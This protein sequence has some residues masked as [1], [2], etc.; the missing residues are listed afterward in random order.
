MFPLLTSRRSTPSLQI[1]GMWSCKRVSRCFWKALHKRFTLSGQSSSDGVPK[2][3]LMKQMPTLIFLRCLTR[4][5]KVQWN[6]L[7]ENFIKLVSFTL[8]TEKGRSSEKLSHYTAT[9]P[10]INCGSIA[11]SQQYLWG[12][13]PECNH[14]KIQSEVKTC[15]NQKVPKQW[16]IKLSIYSPQMLTSFQNRRFLP[17]Q[18]Q[19]A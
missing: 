9:R 16:K 4:F 2:T 11:A 12:A 3:L 13:I 7:L 17:S 19:Q 14:L 5:D 1:S 8:T 18:S 15:R 6:D 10:N